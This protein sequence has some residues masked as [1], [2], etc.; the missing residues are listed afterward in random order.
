MILD[1]F[2]L[3][4]RVALVTG[5]SRGLGQSMALGLAEAGADIVAV[6]SSGGCQEIEA[7]VCET[8]PMLM[9]FP[10]PRGSMCLA[11]CCE[12]SNDALR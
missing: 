12:R 1:L 10:R 6:S 7:L 4:G 3:D 9:I 2:K 5:A 11:A 8:E